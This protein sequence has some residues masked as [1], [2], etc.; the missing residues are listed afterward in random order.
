MSRQKFI[1][2]FR[3][4]TESKNSDA[5]RD[6][7][8]KNFALLKNPDNEVKWLLLEE[9]ACSKDKQIIELLIYLLRFVQF[10]PNHDLVRYF[11]LAVSGTNVLLL[12]YL[13]K[14]TGGYFEIEERDYNAI[15]KRS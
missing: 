6:V 4:A 7:I 13:L 2:D 11:E 5:V 12:E 1:Q 10:E 3:R 14:T 8:F 15:M 9:A